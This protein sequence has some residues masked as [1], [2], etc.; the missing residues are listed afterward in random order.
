MKKLDIII[1]NWNSGNQLK[2]CLKSIEKTKKDNFI[3]NTIIIVDNASTDDSLNDI[4]KINLP[5]EIIKNNKNYGF[6]KACNIGAKKAEGDFILFLNPDM[7]IFEDTFTNLFN[8]VYKH[9]KP[10]IGIYGIQLLDENGNIQKTC[11]R[12][13]NVWNLI[14]RSL[15]LDI[16]N[17]KIF[18]SYRIDDWDHRET[19]IVDQ[20]IGAFFLVKQFLFKKLKGF[21][22]RFFV[23]FEE[24]DFSKRANDF[25]Y[26]TIYI[27]KAKAYHKG[28]GTSEN[29][30]AKR[31]FYNVQSR[32]IYA[33]KHF[34]MSK[35]LIVMFFTWFIEPIVRGSYLILRGNFQEILELI[36]GYYYI[37]KSTID[38]IRK[39]LRK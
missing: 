13:P 33:F 1:V 14:V 17:P 16:I 12:F 34:G 6:A 30:K 2:Y 19:K 27:T 28:G 38:T 8:Y 10:E 39:G 18:K 25:G 9:D 3:I 24:L 4:E 5:I 20:V 36:K 32:V 11:A 26:R 31:L 35:G 15:G 22:E 23:Y 7:I 37:Y 21:D 29:V